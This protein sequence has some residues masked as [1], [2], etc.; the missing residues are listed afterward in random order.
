ML[1]ALAFNQYSLYK[2]NWLD[3]LDRHGLLRRSHIYQILNFVAD[4]NV[5]NYLC[6]SSLLTYER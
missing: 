5:V 2:L 3:K 4:N 1:D 6:K